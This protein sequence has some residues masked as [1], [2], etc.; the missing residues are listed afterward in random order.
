MPAK[1]PCGCCGKPVARTHRGLCCDTCNLWF[2]IACTGVTPKEYNKLSTST[3][4]WT[5]I[6]CLR[7]L[8]GPQT[9][10]QSHLTNKLKEMEKVQRQHFETKAHE[11]LQKEKKEELLE[12]CKK[13]R[14][15]ETE[16]ER[17]E[18]LEVRRKRRHEETEKEREE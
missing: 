9:R 15:E 11:E 2:H 8:P 7:V 5:C 13:R 16:E 6:N 10:L 4:D 18:R 1:Y 14:H 12:I 3:E 17:E